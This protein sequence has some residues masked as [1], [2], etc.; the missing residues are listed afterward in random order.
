MG[1]VAEKEDE[2]CR[3][4]T[5]TRERRR[6]LRKLTDEITDE[7][8]EFAIKEL[9][10]LEDQFDKP[11]LLKVSDEEKVWRSRDI[12]L[13][14]DEKVQIDIEWLMYFLMLTRK[15]PALKQVLVELLI[16]Q[17][18][19]LDVLKKVEKLNKSVRQKIAN[20]EIIYEKRGRAG[21]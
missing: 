4:I 17:S 12:L 9:E 18:D 5:D 14:T 8:I 10:E 3:K 19:L 11:R 2:R 20:Y 16:L 15:F 6:K 13:W 7:E 1:S 21:K